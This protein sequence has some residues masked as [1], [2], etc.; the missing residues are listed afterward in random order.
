MSKANKTEVVFN[1]CLVILNHKNVRERL[2]IIEY[3]KR[4]NE[5]EKLI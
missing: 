3:R 2:A 4:N 5:I 1:T